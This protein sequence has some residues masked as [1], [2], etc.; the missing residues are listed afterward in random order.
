[1]YVYVYVYI[2]LYGYIGI[3]EPPVQ[4][5]PYR[6]VDVGGTW[7]RNEFLRCLLSSSLCGVPHP[8][9]QR[10]KAHDAVCTQLALLVI[11][12]LHINPR[13]ELKTVSGLEAPWHTNMAFS[14]C[15]CCRVRKGRFPLVIEW[16]P[17][18]ACNPFKPG[19]SHSSQSICA[20]G[21]AL[22]IDP[23]RQLVAIRCPRFL[24][25]MYVPHLRGIIH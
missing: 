15:I 21:N 25:Y 23:T 19:T 24:R 22:L 8:A 20:I 17:C 9:R 10:L 4:E 1:M 13:P 2:Y 5:C 3:G 11:A 14:T 7:M 16:I 18:P 12:T 6:E